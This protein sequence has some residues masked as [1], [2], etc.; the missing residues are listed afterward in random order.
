MLDHIE[1]RVLQGGTG[2]SRI[3]DRRVHAD[4]SVWLPGRRIR[5]NPYS[6]QV[7]CLDVDRRIAV[8]RI[9]GGRRKK[10]DGVEV[11][12]RLR[13]RSQ[14]VDERAVREVVEV[15]GALTQPAVHLCKTDR[16]GDRIGELRFNVRD[17]GVDRVLYCSGVRIAG[18]RAIEDGEDGQSS[19]LTRLSGPSGHRN[20]CA[21]LCWPTIDLR[22]P[23]NDAVVTRRRDA[24]VQNL[25]YQLRCPTAPVSRAGPCAVAI[26]TASSVTAATPSRIAAFTPTYP[27]RTPALDSAIQPPAMSGIGGPQS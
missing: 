3:G 10:S 17:R 14:R 11:I 18:D 2:T 13:I 27:L 8:D 12:D 20:L 19:H 24:G 21:W 16:D 9:G 7:S 4:E 25:S 1:Q 22:S 6:P 5:D 26:W 23:T 15:R